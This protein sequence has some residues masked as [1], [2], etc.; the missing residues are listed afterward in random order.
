M[1]L[2]WQRRLDWTMLL[3]PF[4]RELDAQV[5]RELTNGFA[6]IN[7]FAGICL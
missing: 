1:Q 2:N 4:I 6:G 5:A 7:L 3:M